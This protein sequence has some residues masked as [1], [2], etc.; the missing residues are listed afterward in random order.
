MSRFFSQQPTQT[1]QTKQP[2]KTTNPTNPTN[3]AFLKSDFP[4]LN[5]DKTQT[6]T[7][8]KTQSK[9]ITAMNYKNKLE[10]VEP[11][12][13]STILPGHISLFYDKITRKLCI[14]N[15]EII[16]PIQRQPPQPPQRPPS[17]EKLVNHWE[18]RYINYIELYGEDIYAHFH[19]YPF[20]NYN[21]FDE[22]DDIFYRELEELEELENIQD[23]ED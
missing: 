4:D 5:E 14:E 23:N 2:S 11:K 22:L 3:P 9:S 18:K 13:V 12:V 8:S 19:L 10:I 15:S 6:K 21:Y 20:Y 17:F 1:K 7:Q 16:Q